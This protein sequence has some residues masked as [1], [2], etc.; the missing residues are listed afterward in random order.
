MPDDDTQTPTLNRGSAA[1]T[2]P[3]LRAQRLPGA[4]EAPAPWLL[5]LIAVGL[6]L[7]AL[8]LRPA[9]TS[10][11]A[12]L[13]EV[14]E[15]LNMS[16][17][18]AGVLTSVPPLC[19]AV[20]GVMAPRLARRFGAGA[21]V[22]AGMAAIAAGLVV[23][24]YIGSTAGFLAASALA[25]MGIAVSNILM[26]VIVKH[27]FPDRVGTM[28]GLY[29]MALAL[30]TALAAAI[31]VPVTGAL[32]GDWQTGLVV[33]AV[34]AAVAVLPWIVLVRDRT[35][36]PG[37][38]APAAATASEAPA[39]RITRS[40]T[41]WG[42]AC[43]FGLQATA[44]YITMGWMPQIFRDAGVSA[45]TAGLLLAVTMAMGVPLAFVIPRVASR[46]KQQG[47]IV[48]VLGL[49]GLIG[50]AGL[51]LA[52]AAGA[53][54]WAL[55]LGVANCAFPLALTMIGMRARSGAGVVRLSAFAQSTGYLLSI[56]GPLLVGVLYQHSGGWGLPIALMAGLMIPQMVAGILA[57][58]DRTIEDEC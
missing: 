3:E 49:C 22:C 25:L 7:A 31:T 48:V 29:S 32:G 55:L 43:F 5:R 9:I 44:A 37:R 26:P 54:A 47:P 1:R 17:S 27:W 50:Y 51:Y 30:G 20:F 42:L 36:A 15:G 41:A 40:R 38:P 33:W 14:R 2:S 56:P 16:G 10:L 58:R 57:G 19:F 23:R 18:V 8:N 4:G 28:T 11:G 6:V 34:L 21:V 24:P 46:L 13:E 35:P 52:P 45:G 12:L 39:L 53:W